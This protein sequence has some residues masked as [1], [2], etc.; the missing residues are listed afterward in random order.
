M[1]KPVRVVEKTPTKRRHLAARVLTSVLNGYDKDSTRKVKSQKR[2]GKLGNRGYFAQN[3]TFELRP[4]SANAQVGVAVN[5]P[6]HGP[7]E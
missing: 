3:I 5:D 1:E 2:A 4:Q 6:R 7:T